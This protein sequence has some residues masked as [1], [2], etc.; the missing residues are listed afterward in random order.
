MDDAML[1]TWMRRFLLEH[2]VVERNLSRNTQRSYRDTFCL[3]VSFLSGCLKK[4][5]DR[6]LVTDVTGD[7]VRK[8]LADLE[9]E[10]GCRVRTRNQRLAALHAFARFVGDHNPELV[11]WCRDV[12]LVPFKRADKNPLSYLEKNEMDALLAAASLAT[13]QG[14]RDHAVLLFLYNSGARASEVVA[15][16][17][18]DIER[19]ASGSGTVTLHGKGGKTR[20]CPLWNQTMEELRPLV[21]KRAA[22]DHLFLNR[23]GRPLSR[24]GLRDIVRRHARLAEVTAPSL[25]RKCV[26]PHTI[27]HTTATHLLRSGVD[28]NTI[29][30]WLGHVSL[31]T[32]NIY[33][34]IDLEA[35]AK[36]LTTC[37]VKGTTATTPWREDPQLMEFLRSL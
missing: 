24:F 36:A 32:T 26:S 6:L 22:S 16:T 35:K 1:G 29:R 18:G 20:F 28:I 33:A 4:S 12:R 14:R 9:T 5:N 10:R 2:L 31:E 30:A 8:F 27:R 17:I 13:K 37:E 23:Y 3:L 19:D 11:S 25:V 21:H 7:C 15:V 34:E